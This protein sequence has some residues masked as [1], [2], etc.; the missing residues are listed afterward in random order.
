MQPRAAHR[1]EADIR[2]VLAQLGKDIR[3]RTHRH[4]LGRVVAAGRDH[5]VAVGEQGQLIRGGTG[6]DIRQQR[7]GLFIRYVIQTPRHL[8]G[9]ALQR[10]H[11]QTERFLGERQRVIQGALD[12]D[13][14]PGVDSGIDELQGERENDRDGHQRQHDEHG[15]QLAGQ[16]RPGGALTELAGQVPD[17]DADQQADEREP[18]NVDEQ[19]QDIKATE[20]LIALGEVAEDIQ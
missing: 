10:A 6:L 11:L 9:D 7:D 14:E 19:D 17:I 18:D 3:R 20:A 8:L 4:D 12:L 1:V 2:L 15:H 16:A 13:I 5:A